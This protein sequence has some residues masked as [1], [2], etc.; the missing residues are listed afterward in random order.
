MS[1]AELAQLEQLGISQSDLAAMQNFTMGL[2][3]VTVVSI[4]LTLWLA[5]R[6]RLKVGFW[7]TMALLFGPL[8]LLAILFVPTKAQ[9]EQQ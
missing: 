4:A 2:F 7:A 3:A 1:E 8:A 6:K 5:R 9:E